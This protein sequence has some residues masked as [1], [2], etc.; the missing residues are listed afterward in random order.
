MPRTLPV[1]A[2]GHWKVRADVGH[3]MKPQDMLVSWQALKMTLA[4]FPGIC[5]VTWAGYTGWSGKRPRVCDLANIWTEFST[6][7]REG[8]LEFARCLMPI[9]PVLG[10]ILLLVVLFIIPSDTVLLRVVNASAVPAAIVS[11]CEGRKVAP[12]RAGRRDWHDF[13]LPWS[14]LLAVLGVWLATAVCVL[15]TMRILDLWSPE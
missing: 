13:N 14:S 4:I 9:C 3:E 1:P 11:Y 12:P 8:L 6:A 2:A 7:K 10:Y 5:L 15:A